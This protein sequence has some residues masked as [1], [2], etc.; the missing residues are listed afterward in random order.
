[1]EN[2]FNYHKPYSFNSSWYL[3]IF[4]VGPTLYIKWSTSL[5][6]SNIATELMLKNGST[7][8]HSGSKIIIEINKH[9]VL[10]SRNKILN[11]IELNLIKIII[12]FWSIL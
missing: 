6:L 7:L 4:Q 5:H 3:L 10:E 1:M 12:M 2:I 11:H 9:G 8:A